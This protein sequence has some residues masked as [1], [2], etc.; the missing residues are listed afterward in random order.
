MPDVRLRLLGGFEFSADGKPVPTNAS[1]R[2]ISLVAYL[3]LRRDVSHA[4]QQLAFLLWP[5]STEAQARTNLRKLLM[6]L[7]QAPAEI[8]ACVADDGQALRWRTEAPMCVDIIEFERAIATGDDVSAIALYDGDLLPDCYDEWIEPERDRLYRLLI[9]ALSRHMSA[10]ELRRDY[11]GALAAAERL[12][13]HDPLDE[14]TCCAAMSLHAQLSNR[15]GVHRTFQACQ[16]A[17]MRELGVTPSD[18]TRDLH[19]RLTRAAADVPAADQVS[20]PLI[21]RVREW[22]QI[23]KSWERTSREPQCM[24][25]AGEAGIGKTRLAEEFTA[26]AAR[27]GLRTATARCYAAEGA[28]AFAPI[29]GWLRARDLRVSLLRLED[30]WLA[31]VARLLPE[32][33]SERRNLPAS[34]P[35]TEG[36]Q[37]QRLF[38][39]L[40]RAVVGGAEPTVL[41][42]DDAQWSDHD[43]LEWL[44]YLLRYKT[45]ARL[46]VLCTVRSEEVPDNHPLRALQAHLLREGVCTEIELGPLSASETASLAAE[47]AG[48][49]LL[50]DRQA[51]LYR[52]TEGNPLFVVETIRSQ[53]DEAPN[54]VEVPPVPLS[55]QAVI[56]RRLNLLTPG[57]RATAEL[58][59]AIGREFSLDILARASFEAQEALVGCLD[60]LLRRRII[61]EHGGP[62]AASTYDFSHDRIRELT[63]REISHA[64]RRLL[65]QRIAA[66]LVAASAGNVDPNSSQI[67][68]H[69]EQ[70][71][72]AEPAVVH[73]ERA[74]RA[75]RAVHA[76]ADAVRHYQRALRIIEVDGG[77]TRSLAA[78]SP[79]LREA[80]GDIL[81]HLTQHNDA[82]AAYRGALVNAAALDR[83][84]RARVQRKLGNVLRDQ[85]DYAAAEQT[86]HLAAR[87]LPDPTVPGAQPDEVREWIRVQLEL[88]HLYYWQGN[89]AGSARVLQRVQPIVEA[90]G[91]PV[92]RAEFFRSQGFRLFRQNRCVATDEVVALAHAA[93]DA[94]AE[95]GDNSHIPAAIF[96][97]GFAILWHGDPAGAE[98]YLAQS[99]N[100]AERTGDASLHARCATYLTIA[101]RQLGQVERVRECV[102]HSFRSAETADMPEY[103]A[104]AHANAAWLAWRGQ[105]WPGVEQHGQAALALWRALPPNHASAPF[106]W[107]GL[108]P[109]IA[110]ARARGDIAA[111]IDSARLLLDPGLQQLPGDLETHLRCAVAAFEAGNAEVTRDLITAAIDT[112]QRHRLL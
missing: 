57:A 85:R 16:Q 70:A 14:A 92:Q 77:R 102:A 95:L 81:H 65:H 104:L 33:S 60:E 54:S 7:R 83:L 25:I 52:E 80:L 74:A 86:Y 32:L 62:V 48:Q 18:K 79:A 42:L 39:A 99:L 8:S 107:L 19:A 36:W 110:A 47:V 84:G 35:L 10:L 103:T 1:P 44:R 58:A 94:F 51:H 76:N 87:G 40:A 20:I 61:R 15:G 17:L 88:D 3:A 98:P 106:Q 111:A 30:V 23:L 64:R 31:E 28:L 100:L 73:Y 53:S 2:L 108:C 90:Q 68:S 13:A 66:A 59:A 78:F 24:M 4:R 37:R 21:G 97:V 49:A 41:V 6:Q 22:Q 72:L 93:A 38:E 9:G 12:L 105:D 101:L 109:L 26:W 75:A 45:A 34:G 82:L 91:T 46:S 56:Q 67:A 71:G 29:T 112:A 27:Q 50:P 43:S 96:G 63:Y 11:R 89:L 5:D 69:Y 55:V